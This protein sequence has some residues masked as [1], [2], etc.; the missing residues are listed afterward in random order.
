MFGFLPL[1]QYL[2]C[3][4]CGVAVESGELD[5]HECDPADCLDHQMLRLRP[6]V[7]RFEWEFRL[8]LRTPQGRFEAFWA[9]FDRGR[10]AAA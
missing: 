5:G 10:R 4:E 3:P 2:P 1:P 7:E 8:W 9:A 6:V